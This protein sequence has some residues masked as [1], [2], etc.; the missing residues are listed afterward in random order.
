MAAVALAPRQA[1]TVVPVEALAPVTFTLFVP[2]RRLLL[3]SPRNGRYTHPRMVIIPIP[4]VS[5][6]LLSGFFTLLL[7]DDSYCRALLHDEHGRAGSEADH[8][9]FP[10]GVTWRSAP[11]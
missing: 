3:A 9:R 10:R 11:E 6:R 1:T 2:C 7:L 4:R 5:C 8:D